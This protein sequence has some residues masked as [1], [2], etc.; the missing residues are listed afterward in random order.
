[1]N[2]VKFCVVTAV[3]L[4]LGACDLLFP[5]IEILVA[6]RTFE[7]NQEAFERIRERFSGP[8]TEHRRIP[9]FDKADD[10]PEDME[11]LAELQQSIPVESI[12]L[13]PFGKGGPD[14]IR[15]VV[16]TSGISVSGSLVA[17]VFFENFERE[18]IVQR[19]VEVFD[20]CDDRALEWLET[21][22]EIGF[23]NVY[24]RL[25]DNWYAYQSIT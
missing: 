8:L 17:V 3:L 5:Q 19:G 22:R 25:N 9:A 10:R 20:T 18:R 1:M 7:E 23:A 14:S 24:C 13:G 16:G 4:L 12:N 15:V 6:A 2:A 11:F 21:A